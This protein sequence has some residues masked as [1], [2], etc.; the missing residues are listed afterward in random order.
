MIRLEA[1]VHGKVQGVFFRQTAK[2]EAHSLH[3]TG[4]VCNEPNGTV[5]VVAEGNDPALQQFYSFLHQGPPG[6]V[7]SFVEEMW[8]DAS[9]EFPNFT[10]R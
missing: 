7:V 3:L 4:W 8:T 1:V 6:A 5:R 2:Q 10:I 9:G